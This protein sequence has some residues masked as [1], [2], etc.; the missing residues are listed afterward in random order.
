MG[1]TWIGPNGWPV[2][3]TV[4]FIAAVA[5]WL[6]RGPGHAPSTVTILW[7][8]FWWR[9][10]PQL[11]GYLTSS[12]E[13]RESSEEAT[14]DPETPATTTPEND[15]NGIAAA[16]AETNALLFA[17]KADVLA[18]MVQAGKVGETEGIK[19]VFGVGPSSS[20]KTYLTA[21]E[22]LKARLARMQP[23]KYPLLTPEQ[24]AARVALGLSNGKNA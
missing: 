12:R 23:E 10:F 3:G 7:R 1:G 5:W 9:Y 13:D 8:G 4:A 17:A 18:A 11:M 22:L 15:N 20:N 19:I 6:R 21:R 14:T 2:I 24:E 16:M